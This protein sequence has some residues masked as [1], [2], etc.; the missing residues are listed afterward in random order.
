MKATVFEI[1]EKKCQSPISLASIN[2]FKLN[3]TREVNA[4]IILRNPNITLYSIDLNN[5][6]AVFIETPSEVNLSLTPFYYA[7]QYQHAVTVLTISIETMLQLAQSITIN[8][9]KLTVI[10]S[11]GRAGS[12]LASQV[13]AQ[14]DGI[15]NLS[16]PDALTWLVIARYYQPDQEGKLKALFEA[17]VR[18]L[19]KAETQAGWVIKG[20]SFVIELGDWFDTCFPGMKHLFLY[21]DAESWLTSSFRAFGGFVDQTNEGRQA[22]EKEIR[23]LLTPLIPL[24]ASYDAD[25]HLPLSGIFSLMWLSI[26]ECYLKWYGMGI[27]MLAIDYSK[28][29]SD[30]QNTVVKMLSYCDLHPKNIDVIYQILTKD[31]QAGTVISQAEINQ[32][33]YHLKDSDQQEL[34]RHLQNYNI[35]SMTEF[36][37][38]NAL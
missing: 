4:G 23:K 3:Q 9:K 33:N 8:N 19:C 24:L 6:Q 30:P 17:T 32:G 16:E 27:K 7:A 1:N 34:L 38:P 15:I 21:R 13:F 22:S 26:M 37:V 12:T 25:R 36:E 20:R 18:L 2:D 10:Y 11:V 35:V 28:W 5:N 14:V 31:S 29:I